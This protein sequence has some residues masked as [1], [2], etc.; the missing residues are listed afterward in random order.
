MLIER[1]KIL[2]A[3][4]LVAKLHGGEMTGN[5]FITGVTLIC[6][7]SLVAIQTRLIFHGNYLL[8]LRKRQCH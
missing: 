2:V 3:S 1:I 8:A 4:W 5:Q 7:E 6:F